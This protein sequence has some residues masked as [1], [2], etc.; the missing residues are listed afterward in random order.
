MVKLVKSDYD[1][2]DFVKILDWAC[3]KYP[4]SAYFTSNDIPYPHGGFKQVLFAGTTTIPFEEIKDNEDLVGILSYDLKN[5]FE[6]LQ[7]HNPTILSHPESLFFRPELKIEFDKESLTIHGEDPENVWEQILEK[8]YKPKK[9]KISS[10]TALTS[11]QKYLESVEHIKRHI[12]EGDIYEMNYCMA[13]QAEVSSLSPIDLFRKL[14]TKSPMPFAAFFKAN[15]QYLICAS[16]ERFIKKT[17]SKLIAQ[18][19]KGTAKRGKDEVEDQSLKTA[20]LNS[21]K[22]RA[23]NLMIV[24]L[25]RND[26]SRVSQ[27]GS[28][29]VEELFGIYTFKNL[30][31]MISTVASEVNDGVSFHE[32]I[33]KTFPMGS[34]TGA[35]KIK[36]ME[37]IEQYEDFR[38]GWYSGS[39]GYM[40][41]NGDFDFN[42]I[43]RSIFYDEKIGQLYFAVGSAITFD[44]EP[45][46]EYQECLLK[47]KA[48][49]QILEG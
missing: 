43:I 38:R 26:L 4:F 41:K 44:A 11:K 15:N 35:P 48:I 40:E 2:K 6:K 9:N 46:A 10:L 22:E 47:A 31:Q 32:I 23:E 7:S 45:E 8:V 17:G 42:V 3:T 12:I 14:S 13:F 18:P 5:R 27:T 39:L 21:E 36:C 16:P 37:L 34:M 28:V 29:K 19:I 33:S 20:L 24:D 25:M 30:H 1:T 49:I